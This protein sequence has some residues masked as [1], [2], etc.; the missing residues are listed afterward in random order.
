MADDLQVERLGVVR[1][2]DGCA[3]IY[4]PADQIHAVRVM[5]ANSSSGPNKSKNTEVMQA[6]M[7]KALAWA[8]RKLGR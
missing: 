2:E 5:I 7:L 3:V 4:I 6:G 8:E 1:V